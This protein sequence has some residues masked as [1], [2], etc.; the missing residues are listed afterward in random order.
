MDILIRERLNLV[1]KLVLKP[2]FV[3]YEANYY[4]KVGYRDKKYLLL[5]RHALLYM[6]GTAAI[7]AA[8]CH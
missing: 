2:F 7:N 3:Q 4:L 6:S 5:L 1:I 8:V